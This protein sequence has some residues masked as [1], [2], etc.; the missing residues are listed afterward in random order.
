MHKDSRRNKAAQVRCPTNF[1]R[2]LPSQ[3]FNLQGTCDGE[4]DLLVGTDDEHAAHGRGVI[5]I[6]VNH[7]VL[8]GDLAIG[9][10]DHREVHWGSLGFANVAFPLDVAFN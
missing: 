9:V 2:A 6:W 5:R 10:A 3:S 7:V 8:I 4:L 1:S